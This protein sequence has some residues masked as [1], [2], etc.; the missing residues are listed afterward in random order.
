MI[1]RVSQRESQAWASKDRRDGERVPTER[2]QRRIGNGGDGAA[3]SE[4]LAAVGT[5]RVGLS[6]MPTFIKWTNPL[7][8]GLLEEEEA[9]EHRVET[10]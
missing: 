2:L 8:L 3:R 5:G 9:G 7:H 4:S 6:P 1:R 10:G